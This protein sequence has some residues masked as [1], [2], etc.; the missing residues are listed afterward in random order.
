MASAST[1]SHETFLL[2]LRGAEA[3]IGDVPSERRHGILV[4][5]SGPTQ[6]GIKSWWRIGKPQLANPRGPISRL[7]GQL[8]R[9]LIRN[10]VD[11]LLPVALLVDCLGKVRE[12]LGEMP[13]GGGIGDEAGPNC[14][15]IPCLASVRSAAAGPKVGFALALRTGRLSGGAS[16]RD[17]KLRAPF[18]GDGSEDKTWARRFR[19]KCRL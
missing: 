19:G 2:Q 5:V 16:D 7:G 11:C 14:P 12:H 3:C 17:P 10:A 18:G 13:C 4:C 15:N 8:R 1:R 6:D 9:V